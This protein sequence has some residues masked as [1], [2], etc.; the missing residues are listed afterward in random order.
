MT[1]ENPYEPPPPDEPQPR[2][3]PPPS[4]PGVV[5]L[6]ITSIWTGVGF[7][8]GYLLGNLLGYSDILWPCLIAGALIGVWV[9]WLAA[10]ERRRRRRG[11]R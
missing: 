8:A 9:S 3:P 10:R 5:I 4:L 2:R 11:E 6:F 1:S 7:A